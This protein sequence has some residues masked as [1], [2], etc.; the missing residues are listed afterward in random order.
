MIDRKTCDSRVL[1]VCSL[2]FLWVASTVGFAHTVKVNSPW[3]TAL[4]T[5][6]ILSQCLLVVEPGRCP[7]IPA[8]ISKHY[9]AHYSRA[10]GAAESTN[11]FKIYF[12]EGSILH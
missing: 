11:E 1:E 4:Q 10:Q 9:N 5:V 7:A 12:L 8:Q 2:S 6:S 3:Q